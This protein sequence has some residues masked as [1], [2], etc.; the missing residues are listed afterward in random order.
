MPV[1]DAVSVREDI[2]QGGRVRRY[3]VEGR[4]NGEWKVL[5]SGTAIGH[6]QISKFEPVEVTEL[7]LRIMESAA[8]PMIRKFAA[9]WTKSVK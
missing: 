4:V 1:I 9:Y 2:R 7:R 5:A 3:A 6:L 8:K